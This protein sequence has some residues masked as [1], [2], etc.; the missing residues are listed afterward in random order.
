MNKFRS[1]AYQ[2]LRVSFGLLLLVAFLLSSLGEFFAC[3]LDFPVAT[4]Q[5]LE[6]EEKDLD[7]KEQE[8]ESS[9]QEQAKM[10][11]RKGGQ[12]GLHYLHCST[13]ALAAL[14]YCNHHKEISTPP[15]E[16]L[17]HLS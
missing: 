4:I 1:I 11:H 6:A 16:Y 9:E 3:V 17:L 13:G 2:Q 8:E 5:M 12:K 10:C 14:L 7:D 15:P